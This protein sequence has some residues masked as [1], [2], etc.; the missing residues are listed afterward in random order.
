MAS[1]A[2]Y[3]RSDREASGGEQPIEVAWDSAPPSFLVPLV[4]LQGNLPNK[5]HFKWV[6]S[7]SERTRMVALSEIEI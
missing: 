2:A 1:R 3:A 7:I 6:M 4:L 5:W